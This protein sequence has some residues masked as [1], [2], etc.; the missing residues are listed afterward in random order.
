IVKPG[1][2][3]LVACA[4]SIFPAHIA[5]SCH[6][7]VAMSARG[8]QFSTPGTSICGQGCLP[9]FEPRL[10]CDSSMKPTSSLSFSSKYSSIV[11]HRV[12]N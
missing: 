3:R 9:S 1:T 10:R 6:A 7:S 2:K 4:R 8:L 5:R 11:S 12:P